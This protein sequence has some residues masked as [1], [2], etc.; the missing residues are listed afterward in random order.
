[1]PYQQAFMEYPGQVWA[2]CYQ[3]LSWL[4]KLI[5]G[6]GTPADQIA[7]PA[8]LVLRL[9]Q[10]ASIAIDA[11]GTGIALGVETQNMAQIS[12][13]SLGLDPVTQTYFNNR[14][15]SINIASQQ[16]NALIKP[17]NP[18]TIITALNNGNA[19]MLDSGY[20]N[21]CMGFTG[22]T[23]PVGLS[24]ATLGTF[25]QSMATAWLNVV[26]A[27]NVAQGANPTS[28]YDTAARQFRCSQQVANNLAALASGPFAEG[29]ITTWNGA[30]ALP[31]ILLDGS[32]LATSPALL[33][34]QQGLTIRYL[35]NQTVNQLAIFLANLSTTI[36]SQ[37]TTAALSN[38]DTLLD[39]AA[40]QTGNFENWVEIAT[41]N[42]LKPPYP[43]PTNPAVAKSGRQLYMPGSNVQTGVNQ[44][45]P[46][47]PDSAMKT[48]IYFGPINGVQPPWNGDY[49]VITG[50]LNFAL[51]LG[52]RL[53]TPLGSL[54]Y[55]TNYGSRIPAEVGAIQSSDEAARLKQFGDSAIRL[56]KRTGRILSSLASAEPGFQAHYAA[57][58]Q[59]IG[60]G[61]TP[62]DIEATITPTPTN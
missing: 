15:I 54:V 6:G 1:M 23:A 26:N 12:A 14:V 53:Q 40:R 28:A 18:F 22:E 44:A 13:L 25:A 55:E 59:P 35:L 62:T 52:R 31:T 27:I 50:Y 30:V 38:N 4:N 39:L 49:A 45:A 16:I 2:T 3:A 57:V 5:D 34:A 60:P 33:L 21:W 47:Y 46:T 11:F 58:V 29:D 56:D 48:D 36:S 7:N 8:A 19:S 42:N 37:P 41:I 9:C 61:S 24:A 32:A 51:S 43:G 20:L 10:D 17:A